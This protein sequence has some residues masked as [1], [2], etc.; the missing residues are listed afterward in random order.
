MQARNAPRLI[1]FLHPSGL[2]FYGHTP[3]KHCRVSRVWRSLFF[4]F[5]GLSE[6]PF[7]QGRHFLPEMHRARLETQDR[8]LI[9]FP[10]PASKD[11]DI[12]NLYSAIWGWAHV[13]IWIWRARSQLYRS[14]C[15]QVKIHC[16]AFFEIYAIYSL[17]HR[18]KFQKFANFDNVFAI[19][20]IKLIKC[21]EFDQKLPNS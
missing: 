18:S 19:F 9:T 17:L 15:L 12:W 13:K 14:R 10:W 6:W 2:H 1:R 20:Q 16:T 11:P 21:V 5:L 4:C 3:K 7:G 8:H